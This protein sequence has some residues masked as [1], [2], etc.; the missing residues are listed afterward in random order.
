[1]L[2]VKLLLPLLL[3][4]LLLPTTVVTLLLHYY[5]SF[6]GTVLE[7]VSGQP[8][9]SCLGVKSTLQVNGRT[10]HYTSSYSTQHALACYRYI[11]MYRNSCSVYAA[12]KVSHSGLDR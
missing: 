12:H 8:P 10:V 11:V 1:M 9:W 7:M 2:L 5:C 4:L 6:G 3:T